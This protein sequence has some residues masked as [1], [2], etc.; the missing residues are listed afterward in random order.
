MKGAPWFKFFPADFL[1]GV[2]ELSS[3]ERGS[4]I[5][6]LCA[7]WQTGSLPPELERLERIAGGRVSPAV[8]GKFIAGDDGRMRN[9]R[10]ESHREEATA[11]S[12]KA[13]DAAA[14]RWDNERTSEGNADAMRTHMPTHS[15][16]NADG[17]ADAYAEARG[18]RL[19][20]RVHIPEA[21][22]QKPETKKEEYSAEPE[23]PASAPEASSVAIWFDCTG[24]PDKWPL[25]ESQVEEWQSLY[26]GI[27]VLSECK[28]ARAWEN[29]NPSKRKTFQGHARFLVSW[30]KRQQDS[31][32]GRRNSPDAQDEDPNAAF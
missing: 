16:C 11:K 10:L 13:T 21:K 4:Y 7:Q 24:K 23:I 9:Q 2:V 8:L 12:R 19:E 20:A 30:L 6:L 17:Y 26:T 1:G 32:K 29:A 18:Q 3:E 14:K 31:G 15:E 22:D 28:H 27:D 25:T 5:T